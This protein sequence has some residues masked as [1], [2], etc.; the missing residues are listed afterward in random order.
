[1]DKETSTQ[2]RKRIEKRNKFRITVC[3][4]CRHNYYNFPK[5][6]DGWNVGV[7]AYYSCWHLNQLNHGECSARSR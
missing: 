2:K 6:S 5:P 7:E 3:S 1:M 4:G